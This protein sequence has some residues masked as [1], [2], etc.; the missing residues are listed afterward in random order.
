[1]ILFSLRTIAS[2]QGCSEW[3]Y[4]KAAGEKGPE[5]YPQG[6]VEDLLEPRTQPKTIF[7]ILGG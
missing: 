5:A 1:M 4:G 6:Y 7:S 2:I 3:I